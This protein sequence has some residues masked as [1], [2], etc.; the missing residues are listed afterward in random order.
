[1]RKPESYTCDGCPEVRGPGN[2]W[3]L[4]N[5]EGSPRFSEWSDADAKD[6]RTGHVCG[7][8]CAVKLLSQWLHVHHC[9]A[10]ED[11]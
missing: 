2:H 5:N 9:C 7:Q 10:S 4:V 6:E 3:L 11:L 8:Q 1:M